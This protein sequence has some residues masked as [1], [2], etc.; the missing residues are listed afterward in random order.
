LPGGEMG[1]MRTEFPGTP[2]FAASGEVIL[3][4][5]PSRWHGADHSLTE[6]GLSHF[7][8]VEDPAHRR[9]AV[10]PA[11]GAEEDDFLAQRIPRPAPGS[12][13]AAGARRDAESLLASLRS[14]SSSSGEAMQIEYA[15]PAGELRSPPRHTQA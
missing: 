3:F 6:L 14:S 15:A 12:P 4:L 13:G 2:D 1:G 7:E 11:F 9:F 10:R 8:I 5:A